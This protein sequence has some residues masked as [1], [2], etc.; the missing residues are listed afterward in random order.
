MILIWNVMSDRI[1]TAWLRLRGAEVGR[2]TRI[3]SHCRFQLPTGIKLGMRVWLEADV[4][5]KLTASSARVAVGDYTFLAQGCHVNAL[6][7][8]EIGSHCLFGPRC[9]IV[10]HNHGIHPD[11][12]IDEQSCVAHPIRIGNDVWCG[13]GAVILSGVTIGD[14]AVIGAHAVVTRDVPSMAVMAGNP[15]RLIRMRDKK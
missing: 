5:M 2:K 15:A 10:D 3:G 11:R 13:A 4:W 14:G 7:Q 8:V 12:R 1:R 6:E 9:V